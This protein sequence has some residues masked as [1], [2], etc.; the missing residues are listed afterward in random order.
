MKLNPKNKILPYIL[1][2]TL[3]SAGLISGCK[4]WV[5]VPD[6]IN[7]ITSNQVFSNDTQATYALNGLYAQMIGNEGAL[8]VTNGGT[9]IYGG[10]SGGELVPNAGT[11]DVDGYQFYTNKVLVNNST[12]AS[13]FWTTTYKTIYTANSILEGVAAST[14]AGLTDSTRKELTGEAKLARAFCY[15]Y[16]TNFF[17]DVPLVL[18]IDFKK[19]ALMPRTPQKMVYEQIVADLLDAQNLISAKYPDPSGQKIRPNKMAA[20]ALLARVYLYLKDW[21]NAEAQ[22]AAVIGSG[23]YSLTD[24]KDVFLK[25]SA[26]AIWQ[27]QFNAKAGTKSLWEPNQLLPITA[28]SSLPP[29]SQ[30]LFLDPEFFPLIMQYYVPAYFMTD[31]A[32]GIFEEGDQR[33]AIWTDFTPSPNVAPYNG[34]LYRYPT[35]YAA[36]PADNPPAGYNYIMLRLGEQYLIRAEALAQQGK[37]DLAAEDLSKIRK[38]AGLAN[39]TAASAPELLTAIAKERERELFAEWG[40]RFLDLKRRGEATQFLGAIPEKQPFNPGQLLY[41]LPPMELRNDP[42]LIQNPGY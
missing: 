19:T 15:F 7:S 14:S 6:P 25:N 34:R 11:D 42:N 13:V 29:E 26:E 17:A 12:S 35:K 37:T 31:H 8:N 41:P 40:H 3:V 30:E 28:W 20:T 23:Q 27:L 10:L 5:D 38:R 36:P 4:K 22:A 9:T 39:T 32:A 1:L 33:K 18:T 16:L 21:K 2:L 24:L